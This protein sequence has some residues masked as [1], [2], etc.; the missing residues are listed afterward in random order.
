MKRWQRTR[1]DSHDTQTVGG[2]RPPLHSQ[3][4]VVIDLMQSDWD[5]TRLN[6]NCRRAVVPVMYDS[7]WCEGS[8]QLSSV[9]QTKGCQPKMDTVSTIRQT[10]SLVRGSCISAQTCTSA[11]LRQPLV[12]SCALQHLVD[13]TYDLIWVTLL[14]HSETH[15]WC[16][17]AAWVCSTTADLLCSGVMDPQ[18]AHTLGVNSQDGKRLCNWACLIPLP[19]YRACHGKHSLCACSPVADSGIGCNAWAT[20]YACCSL[21]AT[22]G[23]KNSPWVSIATAGLL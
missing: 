20:G 12:C 16:P 18:I 1:L 8:D 13:S 23:S 21:L 3:A 4:C 15:L 11:S 6:P 7:N 17:D 10:R 5:C 2:G 9:L 22:L 14:L 19:M